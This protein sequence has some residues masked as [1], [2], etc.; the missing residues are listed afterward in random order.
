MQWRKEKLAQGSGGKTEERK[1]LGR[2]RITCENITKIDFKETG[3]N[4]VDGFIWL[5][6]D[7]YWA[8]V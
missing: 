6:T 7:I 8:V 4:D 3:K 5:E 1:Q 2:P